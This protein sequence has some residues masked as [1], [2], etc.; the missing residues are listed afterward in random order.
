MKLIKVFCVYYKVAFFV[1]LRSFYKHKSIHA[2]IHS[3][4]HSFSRSF[5]RLIERKKE[6]KGLKRRKEKL[7]YGQI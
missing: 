2:D 1:S 4:D 5:N 3:P 7:I 6:I